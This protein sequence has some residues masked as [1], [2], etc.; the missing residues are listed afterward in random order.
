MAS[1]SLLINLLQFDWSILHIL[2][3][4]I[5]ILRMRSQYLVVDNSGTRC[6]YP[7]EPWGRTSAP[8]GWRSGCR[9]HSRP[10][11]RR[12]RCWRKRWRHGGTWHLAWA[13]TC[14]IRQETGPGGLCPVTGSP[15]AELKWLLGFRA[16]GCFKPQWKPFPAQA[17]TRSSQATGCTGSPQDRRSWTLSLEGRF[18]RIYTT[19][20]FCNFFLLKYPRW[21]VHKRFYISF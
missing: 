3:W 6:P 16:G 20:N 5:L 13:G 17:L 19:A 18:P 2:W 10:P 11:A 15:G 14:S 9:R 1:T 7:G 8:E 21:K 12:W 4:Y